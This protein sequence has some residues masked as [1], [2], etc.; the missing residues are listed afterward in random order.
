M[1]GLLHVNLLPKGDNPNYGTGEEQSL[2]VL[3][4]FEQVNKIIRTLTTL[5]LSIHSVQGTHPVFRHADVSCIS[6]SVFYYKLNL[7][8]VTGTSNK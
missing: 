8:Q 6:L 4:A 3:K 5:P 2:E 7:R 1:D